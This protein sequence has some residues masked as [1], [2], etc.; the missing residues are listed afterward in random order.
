M[1]D[2]ITRFFSAFKNAASKLKT[3]YTELPTQPSTVFATEEARFPYP[4]TFTHLRTHVNA[5]LQ[6]DH[7]P[8]PGKLLYAGWTA[9]GQPVVV[10]FVRSYSKD[11]HEHCA[12]KDL[13]PALLGFEKLAGNWF[14]VV[15]EYMESYKTLSTLEDLAPISTQLRQMVTELVTS[16]HD[17]NFVHGDIRDSN[18][19][20]RTE[21]GKLQMK[22]IDFDWGGREGEVHY[23]ALIN[24]RTVHRPLAVVGGQLIKREH[25]LQ[26]V[27]NILSG[28]P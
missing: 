4:T 14:M 28:L 27:E 22:L 9:A 26:M 20:V 2:T 10:K 16:F 23:P 21:D 25:D 8:I 7:Q 12:F 6:L 15:M 5:P 13:A 19:L 1:L 24:D 3:Y 17:Q 18:L 11:L